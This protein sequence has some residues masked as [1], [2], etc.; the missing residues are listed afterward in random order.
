[1]L[2][3]EAVGDEERIM[4]ELDKKYGR[5]AHDS[6]EDY[7]LSLKKLDTVCAEIGE[8]A[9]MEKLRALLSERLSILA[10]SKSE[11]NRAR[12]EPFSITLTDTTPSYERPTRYNP[13]LNA[14]VEKEI[15]ELLEKEL[16]Y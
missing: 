12:V 14:F 15:Q 9:I 5:F 8:G 7:E 3:T 16:I 4:L 6:W 2:G 1:M 11:L 13:T 10:I